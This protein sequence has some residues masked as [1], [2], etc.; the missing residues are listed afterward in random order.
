MNSYE[1]ILQNIRLFCNESPSEGFEFSYLEN[2][3]K[4]LELYTR[5]GGILDEYGD[6]NP[7]LM[8]EYLDDILSQTKKYVK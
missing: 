2:A 1:E 8:E 6:S 4:M 7:E 3:Q 5:A